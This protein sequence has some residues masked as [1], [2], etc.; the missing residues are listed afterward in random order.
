MSELQLLLQSFPD[1]PDT[2]VTASSSTSLIGGSG[3]SILL[4]SGNSSSS[5]K[6][7]PIGENA[8][9][10]QV[11]VQQTGLV[12]EELSL[13]E[14][15][16]QHEAQGEERNRLTSILITKPMLSVERALDSV[17]NK[18]RPEY[19]NNTIL[20][21]KMQIKGS[22][23]TFA[24]IDKHFVDFGDEMMT[25]GREYTDEVSLN[26][27]VGSKAKFRVSPWLNDNSGNVAFS[28]SPMEG[29]MKRKTPLTFN[30]KVKINSKLVNLGFVV[31]IALE[32]GINYHVIVKCSRNEKRN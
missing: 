18:M 21:L 7:V 10:A 22:K 11:K 14:S 30:F 16:V 31:V 17:Y 20:T 9:G 4:G 2:L 13:L 5:V 26:L 29:I 28:V 25:L 24:T 23:E 1:P 12:G 15:S 3:A 27:I 19:A 32:N 8:G 6:T